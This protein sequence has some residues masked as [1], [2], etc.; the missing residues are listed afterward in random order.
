M[1][2]NDIM[3]N[4]AYFE[5]FNISWVHKN[6]LVNSRTSQQQFCTYAQVSSMKTSSHLYLLADPGEARGSSTNGLVINSL[7]QSVSLFLPQIYGAAM[8]KRLE[9]GLPVI[10][11]PAAQAAGADP[12]TLHQQAKSTPSVK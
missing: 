2:K 1:S 7:I 6:S 3:M 11:M 8:P 12:P 4:T 10:N 5:G 9:I